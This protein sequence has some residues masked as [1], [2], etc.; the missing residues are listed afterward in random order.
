M[1]S[2][3]TTIRE[4][5]DLIT[6]EDVTIFGIDLKDDSRGAGY[7]IGDLLNIPSLGG[8]GQPHLI[9]PWKI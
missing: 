8:F 5:K 9:I 2:N 3:T 4:F 7:N 6:E 1:E